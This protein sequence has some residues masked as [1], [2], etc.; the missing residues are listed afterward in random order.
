MAIGT[1]FLQL[2]PISSSLSISW[3]IYTNMYYLILILVLIHLLNSHTLKLLFLPK[4]KN[5]MLTNSL[6]IPPISIHSQFI[7]TWMMLITLLK[8]ENFQF[9]A[10]S[11]IEMTISIIT[12]WRTTFPLNW[13]SLVT[14]HILSYVWSWYSS[15]LSLYGVIDYTWVGWD[16]RS[17]SGS[18][19]LTTDQSHDIFETGTLW[20]IPQI[21][22]SLGPFLLWSSRGN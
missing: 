16:E 21:G 11:T 17:W 4:I 3:S 22:T 9:Y 15:Y 14:K 6:I 7:L 18:C 10:P 13:V 19:S 2:F 12:L 5:L 8:N 1:L 20:T